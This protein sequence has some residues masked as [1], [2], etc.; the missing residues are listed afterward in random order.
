MI[1]HKSFPIF[2]GSSFV[3]DLSHGSQKLI[4]LQLYSAVLMAYLYYN[5]TSSEVVTENLLTK[6]VTAI[7][8]RVAIKAS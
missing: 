3:N 6:Q 7:M 5:N 4:V 8:P 1:I 2:K